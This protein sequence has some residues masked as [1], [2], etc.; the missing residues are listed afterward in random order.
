MIW[1]IL[2]DKI[3]AAGLASIGEDLYLNTFP[4]ETRIGIMLR[5][6]LT[7]VKIDPYIPGFYK[8]SLQV[9]VRHS[10][11]VEGDR[12]ANRLL[13]VLTITAPEIHDETED[14]G[15]VK[16]SVFYPRELPIQFPRLD[17]NGIEWSINF[18][19]AFSIQRL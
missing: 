15:Q 18:V 9:I 16:I 5:S 8:P 10:D 3:Q 11:P 4:A 13:D 1:D 6:P 2:A 19:T 12:L 17:G 14:R 7:G